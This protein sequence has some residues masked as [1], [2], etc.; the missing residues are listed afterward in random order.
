MN[1]VKLSRLHCR[2]VD[3]YIKHVDCNEE[4]ERMRRPPQLAVKMPDLV[5]EL[6]REYPEL[7]DLGVER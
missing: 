2:T 4:V 6:L 3:E 7:Q 1:G 5:K